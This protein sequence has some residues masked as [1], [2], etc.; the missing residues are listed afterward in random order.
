MVGVC[1][2]LAHKLNH[3][4]GM[5]S[6]LCIPGPEGGSDAWDTLVFVIAAAVIVLLNCGSMLISDGAVTE[7]LM[8]ADEGSSDAHVR[9]S[10][11]PI[12]TARTEWRFER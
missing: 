4:E 5:P 6:N 3:S 1:P 9:A 12:G 11:T 8:S 2:L 7:V 10:E